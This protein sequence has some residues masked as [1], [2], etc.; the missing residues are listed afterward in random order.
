MR[1][2][3]TGGAG[4]IG[5]TV[6]AELIEAGHQVTVYDSLMKGHRGAIPSGA[7]FILGDILDRQ[8]LDAALGAR[9]YDAVIHF[10]AFIEAGASMRQP[11][12]FFRNNVT[13]SMTLI[14]AAVRHGVGR[15]VFSSSAGVYAGRDTALT[16]DDAIG[17]ASVYGHT[18]RMVEEVLHWY[19]RIYELRFA[20]L[21]AR[22][23]LREE[24]ITIRRR[25]SSL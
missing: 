4:Y 21:R 7:D 11:G 2:F 15:F 6:A 9:S 3:V 24:R 23:A 10:A 20:A 12:P 19:H 13:G 14:E 18:K 8:A 16:E 5:S 17:P 1:V 25:T 22:R